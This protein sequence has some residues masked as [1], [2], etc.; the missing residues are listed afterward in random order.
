[1]VEQLN[2]FQQASL[3]WTAARYRLSRV[4]QLTQGRKFSFLGTGGAYYVPYSFLFISNKFCNG[5]GRGGERPEQ[6]D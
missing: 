4:A 1:M 2:R 3:R 5:W 6:G